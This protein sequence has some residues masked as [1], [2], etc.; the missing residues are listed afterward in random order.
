VSWTCD[1]GGDIPQF[2]RSFAVA[3]PGTLVAAIHICNGALPTGIATNHLPHDRWQHHTGSTLAKFMA[4]QNISAQ[5][6]LSWADASK[7]YRQEGIEPVFCIGNYTGLCLNDL[8]T[9][10]MFNAEPEDVQQAVMAAVLEIGEVLGFSRDR[11]SIQGYEVG[12]STVRAA[13]KAGV[14]AF[15]A[16][17]AYQ[18][19]ADGAWLINHSARPLQPYFA[20]DEDFRKPAPR[21]KN[22][23][24]MINQLNKHALT[25]MEHQLGAFDTCLLDDAATGPFAGGRAGRLEV[26]EIYLSRMLDAVEAELQVQASRK[27]PWFLDFG[28]QDFKTPA[29]PVET[30]RANV[31]LFDYLLR[32]VRDGANIVFCGQRGQMDYYQRYKEI[33]ETVDYESNWQ[34]GSKA[35]GSVKFGGMLVDYP[36]AMEIENARYTAWFK[37]SEGMLPAYHWDYTRPWNYPDWGNTQLP[38]YAGSRNL[39]YDTDDRYAVTPLSTDT[40]QLKVSQ[41]VSENAGGWEIVVT[42]KTPAAIKAL[43]LA[44]W[45]IP[46][47]WKAGEGWWTVQGANRFVPVRAPFTGNLNG[48]LEVNAQP[49]SNEYHLIV[50]TPRRAPASQDILLETVHA[51]VFTRDGQSMAYI[52]PT[53]P[54]ETSFELTVP[55]GYSVQYYA[56]PKG[57]RVDLAPGKHQLKIER[58]S[59]S[60]IVGL[61]YQVLKQTLQPIAINR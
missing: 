10:M 16:L 42:L 13:R 8:P 47:E 45:D 14:S 43:P 12:A 50:R 24:V 48:I 60:R 23:V 58:E 1:I 5:T 22:A 29:R 61:D 53:H 19:W 11:A 41:N 18:N 33:P 28:I 56:A 55:A 17:C 21:S 40:R 20:S 32:R 31:V 4:G 15:A 46:R 9:S 36:D 27:A 25:F 7:L 35:Y 37:K 3:G 39:R 44:L 26:D 38:R 54:W 34:C 30:T 59:W 6:L 49:G 51:K 57:D 2:Y 52:W